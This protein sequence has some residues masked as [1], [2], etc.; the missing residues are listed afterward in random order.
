MSTAQ[1]I[2]GEIKPGDY[3]FVKAD[4]DYGLLVGQVKSI[5]KTRMPEHDAGSETDDIRVL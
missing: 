5:A 4:E 2:N 3:V 1:A